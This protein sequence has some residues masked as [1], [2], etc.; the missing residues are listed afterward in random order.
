MTYTAHNSRF[1]HKSGF[2]VVPRSRFARIV[3]LLE[4]SRAGASP[5]A[6]P[7]AAAWRHEPARRHPRD[8]RQQLGATSRRVAT[9][10]TSRRVATRT[11]L[12]GAFRQLGR[13]LDD[14]VLLAAD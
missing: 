7:A 13:Y 5:P 11:P 6:R 2:V 12:R 1:V 3:I 8:Q 14:L 9:R 4:T 10:A